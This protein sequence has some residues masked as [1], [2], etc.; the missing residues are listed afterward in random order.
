M[1]ILSRHENESIECTIDISSYIDSQVGEGPIPITI[2]V[3]EVKGG[4]VRIGFDAP[5]SIKILR[6]ELIDDVG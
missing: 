2:K 1:L 5:A 3:L 4:Q 6:N